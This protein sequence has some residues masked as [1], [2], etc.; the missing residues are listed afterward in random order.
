M[1]A[2][3]LSIGTRTLTAAALRQHANDTDFTRNQRDAFR[4]A[5]TNVA[6]G[7]YI[8]QDIR[9]IIDGALSF[10]QDKYGR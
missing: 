5:A 4:L 10:T 9:T 7:W 2:K 3:V 8:P 6:A 1:T